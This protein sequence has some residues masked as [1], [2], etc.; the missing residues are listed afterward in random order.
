MTI[1]QYCIKLS[2]CRHQ[3]RVK[4]Q[5]IDKLE[6]NKDDL[7]CRVLCVFFCAAKAIVNQK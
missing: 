1:L 5:R 7:Q 6:R 3:I 4:K 2:F